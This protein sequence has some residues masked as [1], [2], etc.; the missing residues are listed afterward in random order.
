ADAEGDRAVAVDRVFRRAAVPLRDFDDFQRITVG[1][2]VVGQNVNGHGLTGGRGR[3]VRVGYRGAIG[4]GHLDADGSGSLAA[5]AVADR[6][7]E[8]VAAEELAFGHVAQHVTRLADSAIIGLG[9]AG[10]VELVA[11]GIAGGGQHVD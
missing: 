7:G 10:N 2:V 6:I 1:V 4:K 3:P 11:V 5:A 9:E 8:A